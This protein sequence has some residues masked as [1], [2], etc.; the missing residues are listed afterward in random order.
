MFDSRKILLPIDFSDRSV[1]VAPFATAFARQFQSALVLLHVEH[2][3]HSFGSLA[4]HAQRGGAAVM[5][6]SQVEARLE[7]LSRTQ[8]PGCILMRTASSANR[9]ARS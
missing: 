8:C 3:P 1:A 2:K 4:G 5:E 9:L 7:T 6:M